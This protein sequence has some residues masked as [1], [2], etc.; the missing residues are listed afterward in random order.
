VRPQLTVEAVENSTGLDDVTVAPVPSPYYPIVLLDGG[1]E[2]PADGSAV[3]RSPLPPALNA[4]LLGGVPA[5]GAKAARGTLRLAAR[6]GMEG[7]SFV[8]CVRAE[9]RA[10]TAAGVGMVAT[11]RACVEISMQRFACPRPPPSLHGRQRVRVHA[12][13]CVHAFVLARTHICV[14]V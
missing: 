1:W 6:R 8:V 11:L 4:T 12:R 13:A 14:C 3:A 9:A 10:G 2:Q 5:A 7:R